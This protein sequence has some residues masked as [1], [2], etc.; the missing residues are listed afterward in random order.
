MAPTASDRVDGK[1]VV[2][3]DERSLTVADSQVRDSVD[4]VRL[5]V[6]VD[7]VFHGW[8]KVTYVATASRIHITSAMRA[9]HR[10]AFFGAGRGGRQMWQSGSVQALCHSTR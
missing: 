7:L 3:A 8:V 6:E 10:S 2:L 9:S 1:A 5:A 4:P